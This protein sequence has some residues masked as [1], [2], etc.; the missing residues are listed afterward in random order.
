[1][2]I[3]LVGTVAI[4]F[5]LFFPWS[6]KIRGDFLVEPD[7]KKHHVFFYGKVQYLFLR[8][9]KQFDQSLKDQ[10]ILDLL[11]QIKKNPKKKEGRFS[12]NRFLVFFQDIGKNFPRLVIKKFEWKTCIGDGNAA[13]TALYCGVLWSLKGA[14]VQWMNHRFRFFSPRIGVTP[15]YRSARLQM[16]LEC[17]IRLCFVQIIRMTGCYLLA[18]N[19]QKSKNKTK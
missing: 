7:E 11:F 17:I 9:Q 5:L 19:R 15:E 18:S 2:K 6:L 14:V 12:R 4:L 3:F 8:K 1:M 16:H 10:E 13:H